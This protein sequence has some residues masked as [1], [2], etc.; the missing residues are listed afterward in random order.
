MQYNDD[1]P[2]SKAEKKNYYCNQIKMY[3]FKFSVKIT[4]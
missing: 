4:C 2:S 3:Y 1:K